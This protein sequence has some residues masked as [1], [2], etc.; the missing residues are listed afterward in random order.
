M[1][2]AAWEFW[3]YAALAVVLAMTAVFAFVFGPQA[4]R[5]WR[6]VFIDERSAS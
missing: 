6:D 3:A 2:S 4:I 5:E 1:S